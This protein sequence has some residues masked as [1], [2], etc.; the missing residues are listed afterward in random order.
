MPHHDLIVIGTSLGGVAALKTLFSSLPHDLPATILVV[1]HVSP[2]VGSSLSHILTRDGGLTV[3]EAQHGEPL[4]RSHAYTA[5]PDHHL[6]IE[7]DRLVLGRGPRENHARPSVDV[8]FRS[9]ASACGPRVIGVILTGQLDDGSAGLWSVKRAGGIAIVQDPLDAERPGMPTS[10][11]QAVDVDHCVPLRDLAALLTRLAGT[12]ALSAAATRPDLLGAPV[13]GLTFACP[14]CQGPLSQVRVPE[15]RMVRFR[16][17][18]GHAYSV[19]SLLAAQIQA[20]EQLLWTVVRT[21]EDEAVLTECAL[22]QDLPAPEQQ[23]L[24]NQALANKKLALHIRDQL[25]LM[26]TRATDQR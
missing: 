21:L 2:T 8:L 20:R 14:D 5:K 1:M 11:M 10:A 13:L 18:V 12:P 17:H 23:D 9:A 15:E 6:L 26:P 22:Q 3:T 16:C 4:Q 24:R 7:N 19:M 25:A